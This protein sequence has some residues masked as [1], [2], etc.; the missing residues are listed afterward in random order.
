MEQRNQFNLQKII[1]EV[2]S[3]IFRIL[4]LVYNHGDICASE[5]FLSVLERYKQTL[6]RLE[7]KRVKYQAAESR[8]RLATLIAVNQGI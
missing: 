8:T 4:K 3:K 6:A 2:K 5:Y 1:Q 7:K